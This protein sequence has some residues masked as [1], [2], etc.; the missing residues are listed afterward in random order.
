VVKDPW[1]TEKVDPV[2]EAFVSAMPKS[3][4]A[5]VRVDPDLHH[6]IE[7]DGPLGR[8]SFVDGQLLFRRGRQNTARVD[9]PAAKL[10]VLAELVGDQTRLMPAEFLALEVPRSIDDFH[11]GVE[12][13]QA[14]VERLLADGRALVEAAERLVCALYAVP[15]ELADEVVTHA[16]AR[17]KARAAAVD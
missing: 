5:S 6:A 4:R 1:S 16:A 8:C 7:T 12:S 17:A 2:V 11:S 14:E 13:A 15:A 10:M 9:G 3:R